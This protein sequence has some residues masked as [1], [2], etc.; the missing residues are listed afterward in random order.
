[1]KILTYKY[2]F[3][4]GGLLVFFMFSS[5]LVWGNKLDYVMATVIGYM[6][7][8]ISFIP[9]YLGIKEVR[10]THFSGFISLKNA[11]KTGLGIVLIASILYAIAW[12]VY[13][14]LLGK[15]FIENNHLK[16]ISE[17]NNIGLDQKEIENKI[18]IL[19]S[20][21]EKYG[22]PFRRFGYALGEIIPSIIAL[23]ASLLLMRK[24]IN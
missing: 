6:T 10:N 4:C 23:L 12:M 18:S 9:V 14:E 20:I 1:M 5:A 2:S 15:E 3:I 22:N 13:Y 17:L 16:M 11:L 7:M 24:T 8:F 19:I 21:K